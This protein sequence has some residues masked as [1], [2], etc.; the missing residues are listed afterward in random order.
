MSSDALIRLEEIIDAVESIGRNAQST[1]TSLYEVESAIEEVSAD[2]SRC[3][4]ELQ[5][6][7]MKARTDP[8]EPKKL[9]PVAN[10]NLLLTFKD[11]LHADLDRLLGQVVVVQ[12]RMLSMYA[13]ETREPQ[14]LENLA[15][16]VRDLKTYEPVTF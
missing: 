4:D 15:R 10:A 2:L 12:N 7:L 13:E 11:V 9:G 3:H 6:E 14:I 5:E 1:S 16:S 8:F